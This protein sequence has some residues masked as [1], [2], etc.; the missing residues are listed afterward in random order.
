MADSVQGDEK[1]LMHSLGWGGKALTPSTEISNQLP[2]SLHNLTSAHTGLW[3][4]LYSPALSPVK[5]SAAPL[6][7]NAGGQ[8][9]ETALQQLLGQH[10]E[11][12]QLG[13]VHLG[14]VVC[15]QLS[16]M[17][18]PAPLA[19][20]VLR[21]ATF[22]SFC[23]LEENQQDVCHGLASSWLHRGTD[24]ETKPWDAQLRASE[25]WHQTQWMPTQGTRLL[26]WASREQTMP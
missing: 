5:A 7:H 3:K 16:P 11:R 19:R 14:S 17:L 12:Q 24:A 6:A 8:G 20:E 25:Q 15:P 10:T 22:V 21:G 4:C 9:P 18:L 2:L 26:Q 23:L 1:Q 13:S